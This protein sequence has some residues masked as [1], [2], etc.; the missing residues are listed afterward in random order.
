MKQPAPPPRTTA[1]IAA[2]L[3]TAALAGLA[4][5]G[6]ERTPEAG[7]APDAVTPDAVMAGL[8]PAIQ[9]EGEPP[10]TWTLDERMAHYAVP[11]VSVAVMDGGEI[12]WAEAWGVADGETGAAVT[13]STLFQ[14]AS[15]SK[16][17]AALAAMS[18][19]ED[20]T[21]ALDG[22][23]NRYL[24]SWQ[25]PDNGFTADSAVTLR[26]LLSHTAGLTVWGFPGY[27]KDQP[28]A[29]DRA[30][31]SNVQV[32]DG[33]GNTDQ[34]R[35]YKVPGTSWQY[36]GGGY[37]VMEQM[38]EDVTG[39]PFHE[40]ARDRVLT[41]AGMTNSTYEQPLPEARWSE[42]A[43]A[44]G[45]DGTEI[46][47][48]WHSYP[49]QAA[50]GLWTTPT[51]LMALARHLLAVRGG[52]A[53]D[54]VVS[55]ET[56]TTMLTAH[57]GDEDGFDDYGLGFGVGL[58]GGA[59][60]FGHGGSN[61]GFKAQWVVYPET[62][63]GAAVMTNGDRGS[64]LAAE[65][66]R[67][68]SDAYGWPGHKPRV[69]AHEPVTAEQAAAYAGRYAMEGRPAFEVTVRP[70]EAGSGV[71]LIDVPDQGTY[72][73]HGAPDSAD[74]FFDASDGQTITFERADDGT[75]EAVRPGGQARFVRVGTEG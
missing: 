62:G 58:Q 34:V 6:G 69:R 8:Q 63:Q 3:T 4:A 14:A 36:S 52:Q 74:T 59:P 5:C 32:L 10:A 18:V 20:G 37:T 70:G 49:E 24:T 53:T 45:A 75:V 30:V 29:A 25:V 72:T 13:P 16:P 43:R 26:G 31:A 28:Y 1:R 2:L 67:A 15:I 60:T 66:L 19:V 44:H 73:L 40:V 57:R 7:G 65:I 39:R 55:R 48:E 23:V 47:G 9:L 42:A 61:A 50:A 21:L 11:G 71:L 27:R 12:V 68:V 35:V 38:V 46:E 17:V 41:P 51:D 64:A 22:P 54:G 56:L 33:A